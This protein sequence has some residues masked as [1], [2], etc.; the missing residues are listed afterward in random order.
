MSS[1]IGDAVGAF[2]DGVIIIALFAVPLAIWK[3]IDIILW[4]FEHIH[5]ALK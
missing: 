2:V 3:L 1:G 5:I 4:A